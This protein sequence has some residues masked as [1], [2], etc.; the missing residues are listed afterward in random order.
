MKKFILLAAIVAA[1]AT[2]QAQ[3][4]KA[5]LQKTFTAFDTTQ[6]LQ[7]KQDQSNRI[8]LIAKKWDTEWAGHYYNALTKGILS[9]MEK[10]ANKRDA[11]LDEADK[12][13]ETAVAELGKENDDT[14]VLAAQ[15]ANARLAVDPMNRYQKYGAIFSEDL[16]KAK[17]INADNP[18]IYFLSGTA[19]YFTPKAFGGGKKA[20]HPYFEKADLLFAKEG[21]DDVT[22]PYWGY[23]M[24]AYLLNESKGDD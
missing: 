2:A 3:N 6:D 9:Y 20:S 21:K 16:E 23:R 12:E 19:K 24:N 11:Y 15:L 18:R 4:F 14:Y 8:G 13:R 17:V 1:A 10:D 22:K 7:K 5:T